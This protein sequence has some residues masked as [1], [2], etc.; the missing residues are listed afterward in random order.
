[1]KAIFNSR[2]IDTSKP[3]ISSSNRAFCYGD[4]LFETIVTGADRIDLIGSHLGRMERGC[5]ILGMDLPAVLTEEYL[6]QSIEQLAAEN[7]IKGNVRTKLM[8]WRNEG[9]LYAPS[10]NMT[11]FLLEC[12]PATKPFFRSTEEIG[13]SEFNH[14][15]WSP[16]S[17][18][19]T[20]SALNYVLAGKEMAEKRWDEILLTD[21]KGNLSETHIANVF[22]ITNGELYTP[23]LSTGCI[24]GVMRNALLEL[25][26][27]VGISIKESLQTAEHLEKAQSIFS[28]NASGITWF[29][30]FEGR[31]LESPEKVLAPILKQLPQP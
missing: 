1:M 7:G 12:K 13:I 4:G 19:K 15:H 20:M 25:A 21:S 6:R 9:G 16:I 26:S 28:T 8:V 3:L 17:F 27:D 5:Q 24:E 31:K 10:E 2:I 14:T 29:K 18:A 11:S 30:K 23:S 22:W